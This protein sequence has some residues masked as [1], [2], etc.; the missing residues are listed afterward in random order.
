M[1]TFNERIKALLFEFSR[2]NEVIG[3]AADNEICLKL[4]ESNGDYN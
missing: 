3:V 1:K 4:K 2:D